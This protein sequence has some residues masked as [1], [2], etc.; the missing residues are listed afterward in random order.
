MSE[1]KRMI[2]L[3]A[4]EKGLDRE[5]LIA[6]LEEAMRSAARRMLGSK[7][8]VDVAYND[9]LGE[10]EVFE[11]KEVVDELTDPDVQVSL[12]QALSLDPECQPGDE[13][14]V[15]VET[16]DFG[17]I[18]AQS[19]KQVIIQ[20]MKDAE[21][22]VIY[23]DFKD[24][25]SE[26]INGIVQRFDKGA[27]IV[28]LGRTEAVLPHKEQ[29]PREGYRPGERIRAY[30]LD[31]RR[32]SRGPQII[33]S[34]T[35]PGFIQALFELEVPEISE[36]IVEVKGVAREAGSRTKIGVSS[37]DRDV[38]PV[39]ACVGMKGSRVQA[40]VQE[41]RGEKIDIIAWDMD[42]AKYVVNALAPA[43]ISRVIVDEVQQCM[44][45]IVADEM[46]SLAIGR[47]GQNVR[48]ASK[49]TGWR[50]DVKSESKYSESLRD[51]YRSLLDVVGVGDVGADTLFQAGFGSAE[52]LADVDIDELAALPG[53]DRERAESLVAD[54]KL[55]LEEQRKSGKSS[56]GVV[57]KPAETMS[58]ENAFTPKP[59]APVEDESEEAVDPAEESVE[60]SDEENASLDEAAPQEEKAPQ[61]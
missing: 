31:V 2:D 37:Q 49:L 3:V 36:G 4:R 44:E 7:V 20:R 19:A 45:V 15:K 21:R 46:L 14:G 23:E 40:V 39:G 16:A 9:E 33:L 34:R 5:I 18:A 48:L 12:E 6:T 50:I 8:E 54:A 52:A 17:R 59:Q 51:G 57:I 26:I 24:R 28:N 58:L 55:Y 47:R 13:L 35:H 30:V 32:I 41:L 42:P 61:D 38:D 27:I 22:D 60:N 56:V 1:L 10:V 25:K 29:V 11:F 53:I 43:E